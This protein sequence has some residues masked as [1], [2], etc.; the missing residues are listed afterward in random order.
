MYETVIAEH[1]K[2]I[3]AFELR[4]PVAAGDAVFD[5]VTAARDRLLTRMARNG[6]FAA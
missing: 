3:H 6:M 1:E 4:D 2:I 5:H